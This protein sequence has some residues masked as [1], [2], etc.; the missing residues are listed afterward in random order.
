MF[1]NLRESQVTKVR[2]CHNLIFPVFI[3]GRERW[4]TKMHDLMIL[5]CGAGKGC[6]KCHGLPEKLA[7]ELLRKS[8]QL[9]HSDQ[10]LQH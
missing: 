3:Y 4:T 7:D 10:E 5:R 9:F 8:S 2:L 1:I 6:C